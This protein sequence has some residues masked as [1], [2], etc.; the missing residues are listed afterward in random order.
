MLRRRWDPSG[1]YIEE[2]VFVVSMNCISVEMLSLAGGRIGQWTLIPPLEVLV[3]VP[4]SMCIYRD[5]WL[6]AGRSK[7]TDSFVE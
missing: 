4:A 2:K 7:I 1:V 6:L 5:Q 3:G